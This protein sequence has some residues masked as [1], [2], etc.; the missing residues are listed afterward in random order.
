[1]NI[2][3]LEYYTPIVWLLVF[4]VLG[5]IFVQVT[6][7]DE[8]VSLRIVAIVVSSMCFLIAGMLLMRNKS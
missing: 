7:Y 6:C 8:M 3:K 2:R 5:N 1:M 4:G